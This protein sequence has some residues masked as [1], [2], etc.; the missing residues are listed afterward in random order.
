[1]AKNKA[2]VVA[3][4]K[5]GTKSIGLYLFFTGKRFVLGIRADFILF[6]P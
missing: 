3:Q 5:Q 4:C 1:M 6:L 2:K